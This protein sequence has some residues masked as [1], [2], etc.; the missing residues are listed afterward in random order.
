MTNNNPQTIEQFNLLQE[1]I[2]HDNL[3]LQLTN[4]RKLGNKHEQV[5]QTVLLGYYKINNLI[6]RRLVKS[7]ASK[8]LV[9]Q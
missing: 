2:Y 8:R 3:L 7:A 5:K 4:Y 6:N 1:K 9:I